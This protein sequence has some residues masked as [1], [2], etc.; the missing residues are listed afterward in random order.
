MIEM[1]DLC[2]I[3]LAVFLILGIVLA[4]AN[5]I[6]LEDLLIEDPNYFFP[7]HIYERTTLNKFGV[8]LDSLF[9][10]IINF[11]YCTIMIINWLCHVGREGD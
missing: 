6:L 4:V 11:G 10:F 8:A 3:F 2:L 9:L 5:L 1:I 7:T